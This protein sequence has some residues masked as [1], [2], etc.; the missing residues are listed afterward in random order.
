MPST[1]RF[2]SYLLVFA[3]LCMFFVGVV[4]LGQSWDAEGEKRTL[5][6]LAVNLAMSVILFFTMAKV[7]D[8]P[9]REWALPA[10]FL[11]VTGHVIL[12][13]IYFAI[14]QAGDLIS[15]LVIPMNVVLL[16]V[17]VRLGTRWMSRL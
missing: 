17:L 5:Q 2:W 15:F 16:V 10:L 9:F 3:V 8:V 11:A 14:Y 13:A 4:M 1:N 6:F 7:Y 12:L